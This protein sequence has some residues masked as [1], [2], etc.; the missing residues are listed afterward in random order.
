[1][2][3]KNLVCL[4]LIFL[5]FLRIFKVSAKAIY[6]LRIRLSNNPLEVLVLHNDTLNSHKTPRKDSG[7]CNAAL[8]HGG[9]RLRPKF[10]WSG[11]GVGRGKGGGWLGAHRQPVCGR[12]WGRGG[13]KGGVRWR[14]ASAV[15]RAPTPVSSRSGQENGR[16]GRLQ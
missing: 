11:T 6:Y 3:P 12:S 16:C 9:R 5:C 7:P 1:M 14:Q 13:S 15:T 8:S 4:F 10:R 2:N